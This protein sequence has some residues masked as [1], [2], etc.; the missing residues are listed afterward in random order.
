MVQREKGVSQQKEKDFEDVK[1]QVSFTDQSD[2]MQEMVYEI[3]RD[4]YSKSLPVT[5]PSISFQNACTTES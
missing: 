2:D 1:P 3:C 4:A 5:S